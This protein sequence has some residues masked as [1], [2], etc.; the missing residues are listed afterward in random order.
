MMHSILSIYNKYK[1]CS[2]VKEGLLFRL[3]CKF[4]TFSLSMLNR[5]FF[6]SKE[7]KTNTFSTI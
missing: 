5:F 1:I 3:V 4:D 7:N 2:M 6:S